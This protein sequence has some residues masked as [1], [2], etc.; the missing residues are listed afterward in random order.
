MNPRSLPL[1]KNGRVGNERALIGES[2]CWSNIQRGLVG[3]ALRGRGEQDQFFNR[4]KNWLGMI[5]LSTGRMLSGGT[6]WW[7]AVQRRLVIF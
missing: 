5:P 1:W 2:L 4:L 6:A 7:S 3:P